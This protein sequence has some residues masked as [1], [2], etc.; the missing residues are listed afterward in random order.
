MKEA[1][2]KC[3]HCGQNGHNSR[4]CNWKGGVKLFGVHIWEKNE[5]PMKKS[6][7]LG[8][9]QYLEDNSVHHHVQDYGYV[10]D[11]FISSKRGKAAQERKKGTILFFYLS[12]VL[13]LGVF[14][15]SALMRMNDLMRWVYVSF[16]FVFHLCMY[17]CLQGI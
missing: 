14:V 2:R 12:F 6:V 5:Q 3:S 8:N 15:V 11:G 4:T 16:L 17:W 10:S 13:C 9:L 1:A 7:S